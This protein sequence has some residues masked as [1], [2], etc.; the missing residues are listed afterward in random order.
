MLIVRGLQ[1]DSYKGLNNGFFL[2]F[3]AIDI[4]LC[5]H[6]F[7]QSDSFNAT[8]V[9][10][11]CTIIC[12]II[13]NNDHQKEWA[14]TKQTL[15]KIRFNLEQGFN[16]DQITNSLHMLTII[17][18]CKVSEE[19][20]ANFVQSTSPLGTVSRIAVTSATSSTY[21]LDSHHQTHLGHQTHILS[22]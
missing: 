9:N 22:K 4:Y 17:N 12:H 7:V 18:N 11:V 5:T 14:A 13:E 10:R 8:Q 19:M 16:L 3:R 15:T 1:T 21:H 20:T 6:C 2:Q